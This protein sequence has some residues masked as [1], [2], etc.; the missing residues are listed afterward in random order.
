MFRILTFLTVLWTS[1]AA[2]QVSGDAPA[3]M[4]ILPGW[5][6]ER[7]GHHV[8]AVQIDLA[9]GWKTY[10]RAP[11]DAGIPPQWQWQVT[12][13][14]Q[15]LGFQ[16]PTPE[17]SFD[18]G[19]RSIGYTG[20]LVLPV[21]IVPEDADAPIRLAGTV[22]IG[23]CETICIPMD[24]AFDITLPATGE[25]NGAIVS[26]LLDRPKTGTELGLDPAQ[27]TAQAMDDG[28]LLSVSVAHALSQGDAIVVETADPSVWVSEPEI[29][30]S[31]DGFLAQ[32]R[33]YSSD[34]SPILLD[35]SGVVVTILSGQSAIEIR[36]CV[37]G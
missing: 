6:D 3:E 37:G 29:Q 35:R 1:A 30:A 5:R 28:L 15:A 4:S 17:V 16:W 7:S 9:P 11:G 12:E 18:N 25:R 36:G 34:G 33:L 23:V 31:A 13:N 2:A 24:F 20:G 32:S 19:M 27:C 26:A 14:V 22:Q 21:R 8:A 10:W